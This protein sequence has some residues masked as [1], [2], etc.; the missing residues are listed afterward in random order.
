QV[1]PYHEHNYEKEIIVAPHISS[2]LDSTQKERLK[3]EVQ[4]KMGFIPNSQRPSDPAADRQQKI[5]ELKYKL[6]KTS[7]PLEDR[8]KCKLNIQTQEDVL[9]KAYKNKQL[10]IKQ[11][12]AFDERALG[13][14]HSDP[15]WHG[16]NN[17]V[18]IGLYPHKDLEPG[19]GGKNRTTKIMRIV[20][21]PEGKKAVIKAPLDW[22]ELGLVYDKKHKDFDRNMDQYRTAYR[23]WAKKKNSALS[24]GKSFT[25]DPPQKP[26]SFALKRLTETSAFL[27]PN[28][29]STHRE[30]AFNLLADKFFNLGHHVAR[31]SVFR[32]PKTGAPWSAQEYIEGSN[33]TNPVQLK[34]HE[35]TG[36]LHKLAAMDVI[37]GNNDRHWGNLKLDKNNRMKLIDNGGSFDYSNRIVT[38]EYPKYINHVLSYQPPKE[39]H[40]WLHGLTEAG[41]KSYLKQANVPDVL[42]NVALQRLAA[43][44]QWSRN[45]MANPH[46]S[47]DFAGALDMARIP[48]LNADQAFLESAKQALKDRI[49]RGDPYSPLGNPEDKT[50][51]MPPKKN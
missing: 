20:G 45:A 50:L 29:R 38:A 3:N 51:I 17:D 44:K 25:E 33:V 9:V 13:P 39:F 4:M 18:F 43:M 46:H 11:Y 10:N 21:G 12:E 22:R 47:K 34:H 24:S 42:G 2:K 15:N 27:H 32:H 40:R 8:I 31:T 35:Q 1:M 30:A 7:A 41:M 23:E 26:P 5:R 36:D 6:F 16:Y 19:I 14:E 28:F 49:K 37:L 48:R